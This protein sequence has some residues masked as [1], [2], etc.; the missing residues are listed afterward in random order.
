M[1]HIKLFFRVLLVTFLAVSCGTEKNAT[2]SVT[3][4]E[5]MEKID[6]GMFYALPQTELFFD[7]KVIRTTVI[8]GPYHNYATKLLGLSSV[9]HN[10]NTFFELENINVERRT[11]VDYD[12]LY[13]IAPRGKFSII[14]KNFTEKGWIL[15]LDSDFSMFSKENFFK[16]KDYSDELH[17]TDLSV[18]KFYG[19]ETRKVYERVWQDSIYARVPTTKVDTVQ[20]N[21]DKKA[22]EAANFI[23]MIR[24]KRFELISG[25]GDF[26]PEGKA[27]KEALDEMDTLE[28]NYLELFT[29]KKIKDTVRHTIHLVPRE[30]HLTEPNIL[31]R[32]SHTDGLFEHNSQKGTPVWIELEKLDNPQKIE[33][34]T[35]NLKSNKSSFYFRVP[36]K[37]HLK[38]KLSDED[39]AEKYLNVF[40]FGSITKIPLDYLKDQKII[41]FYGKDK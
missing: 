6:Q 5:D 35:T 10:Y 8:P 40:Q 33:E 19:E 30:K 16:E 29:G 2:T 22:E 31:F 3:R 25:M 39:I 41:E 18:R 21:L 28:N 1:I 38:L 17:Y 14:D 32:F 4:V 20:K 36:S 37:T 9:P 27:M 23:F 13:A 26:Y 15:P 7:V 34:F 24:E 12:H 11:D